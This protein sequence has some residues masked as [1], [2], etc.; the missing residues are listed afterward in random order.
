LIGFV[1]S[2][3]LSCV[4][5]VLELGPSLKDEVGISNLISMVDIPINW[6][7]LSIGANHMS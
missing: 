4:L 1:N 5:I 3:H 2:A 6:V 7:V